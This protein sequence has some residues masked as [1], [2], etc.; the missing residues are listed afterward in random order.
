[1]RDRGSGEHAEAQHVHTRRREAGD[2]GGLEELPRG[3]RVP[4]HDGDR[5][6]TPPDARLERTGI[7]EDMSGRDREVHGQLRREVAARDPTDA[8]GAE[9][10]ARQRLLY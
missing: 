9:Q 6:A 2:H 1:M 10:T 7:T 8:V 3:T 5:A 4:A